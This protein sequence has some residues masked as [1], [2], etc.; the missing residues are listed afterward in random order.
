MNFLIAE[1]ISRRLAPQHKVSMSWW[2]WWWLLIRLRE[3]GQSCSRE[4]G[5]FLLGHRRDDGRLRISE[6][7]LYDD[8]DPH[9]LDSG[10][11]RF[12]GRYFGRLWEICKAK[13]LSVVADIHVHP[14]GEGQSISDKDNPM[15]SRPGHIALILPRFARA[16]VRRHSVGMYRYMGEKRWKNISQDARAAFLHIG[17]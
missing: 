5:A 3:R 15:I 13:S 12:D 16:P 4:S 10:I 17:L 14:S 9:C 2:T 6:F 1:I 11:V 8:L 7:V